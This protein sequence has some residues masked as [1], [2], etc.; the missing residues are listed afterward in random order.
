MNPHHFPAIRC[1]ANRPGVEVTLIVRH[2]FGDLRDGMGWSLPDYGAAQWSIRTWPIGHPGSIAQWAASDSQTLHWIGHQ[3]VEPICTYVWRQCACAGCGS[4]SL[5]PAR[6]SIGAPLETSPATCLSGLSLDA[7]RQRQPNL[8]DR[9]RLGEVF[10]APRIPAR[11]NLSWVYFVD[12]PASP[13][14]SAVNHPPRMLYLGRLV[15][16]KNVCQLVAAAAGLARGGLQFEVTIIGQGP[17]ESAVRA[18]IAQH[19][20]AY[21]ASLRPFLPPDEVHDAS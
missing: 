6:A 16:R 2:R 18:L 10:P 15:P 14:S 8:G 5:G 13:S 4:A 17:E 1:L 11:A 7:P 9:S 3:T 21:R 20:L 12:S 19:Q